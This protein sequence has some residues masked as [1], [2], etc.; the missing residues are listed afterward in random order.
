MTATEG[1]RPWAGQDGRRYPPADPP[2]YPEAEGAQPYDV[3]PYP[4][5]EPADAEPAGGRYTAPVYA[6]P[7]D[8][9]GYSAMA[10]GAA[11]TSPIWR[12]VART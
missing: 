11:A 7:A 8:G 1:V 6:R 4:A 2:G 12:N 9:G 10:Q 5:A 3:Y